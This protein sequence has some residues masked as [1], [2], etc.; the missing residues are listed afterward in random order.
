MTDDDIEF[1][2][3]WLCDFESRARCAGDEQRL[4]LVE[5][6]RDFA[7][8]IENPRSVDQIDE[9]FRTATELNEPWL[10]L[11]FAHL[12]S[13]TRQHINDFRLGVDEAIQAVS[14]L[15]HTPD[16]RLGAC[17][18][19]DLVAMYQAVDGPGYSEKVRPLLKYMDEAISEDDH[20]NNCLKSCWTTYYLDE[21]DVAAAERTSLERL[22]ENQHDD[23]DPT[24][25]DRRRLS[26]YLALCEIAWL[27]RDRTAL[28]KW[29]E[30]SECLLDSARPVARSEALLWIATSLRQTGRSVRAG[31][32]FR[33]ST[34]GQDL[35]DERHYSRYYLA[36]SAFHEAAEDFAGALNV[37][38]RQMDF[39][40]GRGMPGVECAC[41]LEICLL[42]NRL[43][44]LTNEDTRRFNKL[45]NLVVKPNVYR[46]RLANAGIAVE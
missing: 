41:Q 26:C 4:E 16:Y 12:K 28:A 38:R 5:R 2:R 27:N 23:D 39:I 10:Q 17:A 22:A 14:L 25:A 29:T 18:Y 7:G 9:C 1:V 45:V 8:D 19:H 32:L 6:F 33:K 42:K 3:E 11:L 15:V 13:L 21:G 36:L 20:C 40:H 35:G 46:R 30:S 44:T 31:E 43:G 34:A 37:R 24:Q